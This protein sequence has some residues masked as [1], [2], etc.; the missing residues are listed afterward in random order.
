MAGTTLDFETILGAD[1]LA[2]LIAD[3]WINWELNK[4]TW[5]QDMQE[6]RNYLFATDTTTTSN[7][8]LPWKNKTTTP[9]LT[10]IRDNLQ[11]NYV[12]AL[13]PHA[14]W[15]QWLGDDKD[16]VSK[17]KAQVVEAYLDNKTKK[18]KFKT[19]VETLVQ[20]YIDYG[21]VFCKTIW[22]NEEKTDEITGETIRGYVGPK[23]VRISPNDIVFNPIAESFEK[24]PKI[25]RKLVTLGEIKKAIDAEQNAE[26]KARLQ[27]VLDRSTELRQKAS[28]WSKPDTLKNER[29]SFDGFTNL[30]AYLQSGFVEVLTFYGDIYDNQDQKIH[31]D[32]KITIIDR[33]YIMSNEPF[34]SW[35]NTSGIRHVGWRTRPDN[36]YAMGPLSNL[37]GL[38]YRIDHLENLK[39][40]ALDMITFPVFKVRGSV[41]MDFNYQPNERIDVGD[42]GDVTFMAPD[43]AALS[44]DFQI[45]RYEQL[46]EEMAGAP[47]EAMG[48]RTAGE[49]TAFEVDQLINASTRVFLNKTGRFEEE[50]IEP[51][52]MDMLEESRRNFSQDELVRTVNEEGAI[53]FESIT[54]ED[55]TANGKIK[56][57]GATHF[58]RQ[59]QIAQNLNNLNLLDP[60]VKEHLSSVEIAK[61][62]EEVVNLDQFEIFEP[63]VRTLER[64]EAQR[65]ALAAEE[66]TLQQSMTREVEGI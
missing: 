13:F 41:D 65:L 30:S 20:D 59:R 37:V 25:I 34:E 26:E 6:T 8:Q 51:I 39:A 22:V 11:V 57:K 23:L 47:R 42:D 4:N 10:Q 58:A 5:L 16:S 49:K 18:A 1:N 15:M 50:I 66:E 61:L 28:N 12:D 54:K 29:L 45:Q 43:N 24:S 52:L 46:M 33:S 31:T 9:K 55:I 64:A 35:D 56:A 21:N 17:E 63:Y 3:Q 62:M 44:A 19:T 7:S 27:E 53:I 32:R 40:D 60:E 2:T 14:N 36:L 48:F 38:Q